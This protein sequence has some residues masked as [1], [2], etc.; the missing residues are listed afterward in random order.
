[1]LD[2]LRPDRSRPGSRSPSSGP[3]ASG[4]ST[5]AQLI[6]RFYDVDAGRVLIDGVDVRDVAGA[7][8][9]AGRSASCSRRRS[10]SATRIAANI[11]FADPDADRSSSIERAARL[12]GADEFIG[13]LPDGYDTE[14]GERGFSLSGGQRQRIAIARAILADPRVLILDDATSA[15]DPTKEHEIRDALAEVMRGRTT[16]VIA[17]RPAT[18]ALAD[19]VVLLDDGRV[20]A[21]GTH[22]ELLRHE[23]ALPR[24][25][26]VGRRPRGAG[27]TRGTRRRRRRRRRRARRVA[28]ATV[29]DGAADVVDGGGRRGGQARRRARPGRSCVGPGGCCGPTAARSAWP[30]LLMVICTL[31]IARR[32]LP[33]QVRHRPGHQRATTPA[34]SNAAVVAYVVVADRR[35]RRQPH[36][37]RCSSAGSARASC[38]TCASG[39]STTCSGCRCRSTTARR[40]AC[41]VSRMTSDVDSLQELVQIGLLHVREQRPAARAVGRRAGARVLA[42][43]AH[44]PDPAAVRRAGQHQVPARLEPGLPHGARPHRRSRCRRCRRASPAS[45]SSRP[46]AARTSR[47]SASVAATARSTT[48]TCDRCGS[49]RGTCRSSSS[50]A[51][52]TTALVRRARRP[53]GHRAA[54]SRSAPSPS[55]CSRCRTCSSRCSSSR[56]LFNQRAV[57]RRR[58]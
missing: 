5:V 9:C 3:P 49:R 43:P 36:P 30:L 15:V 13:E 47:S 45:G 37:G 52:G 42:A 54:S 18:I 2:E 17:H 51:L 44:L 55:S 28:A 6:P 24:G 50:P 10:S 31:T 26:G 39:C 53:A 46:T 14:I 20:V 29:G 32:A 8:R 4:K 35:L 11:A 38:A 7:R 34:R 16:I 1:M 27:A 12:A 21:D 23:R 58:R 41:I 19:R 48:P 56:Q 22:A 25:A 57:G 33:G 40:P